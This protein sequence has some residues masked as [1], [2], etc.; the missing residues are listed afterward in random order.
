M[1]SKLD[2][3][4]MHLLKLTMKGEKEDGWTRVSKT[5]WPV[6]E[7][8]PDDLIEKLPFPDGNGGHVRLTDN[9]KTIVFYS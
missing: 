2:H 4:A 3:G 6:I 9:G 5:A 8:L 1:M 7:K